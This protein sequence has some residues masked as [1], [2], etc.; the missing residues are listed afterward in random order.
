MKLSVVIP[1][2]NE[3][4]N[5]LKVIPELQAVLQSLEAVSEFE[6][7]VC[8]DHSSDNTFQ[9]TKDFNQKNIKA[10]RLSRRSGSHTAIRAGLQKATGDAVLCIS[11]DGQDNPSVLKEMMHKLKNGSHTVWAVRATRE[12]PFLQ[13]YAAQ[14]F[15]KLFTS[16]FNQPLPSVDLSNADFFLIDRKVV[17]GLNTCHERHTAL[18]GLLLHMG[19]NHD[20]VVYERRKRISGKSK[21]NFK[22][23]WK[24]MIDSFIAFSGFPIKLIFYIGILTTLI[25]LINAVFYLAYSYLEYPSPGWSVNLIATLLTS[26]V[27]M[28]MI[29]GI[30]EYLYRTLDESRKRPLFF[31]EDET[32]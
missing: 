25:G 23:K 27:Q 7:I 4:E 17:N 16:L 24:I 9:V 8:D 15:Y 28:I 18:L 21:W 13:K 29:G 12:E 20:Y 30:G 26:G 2:Y 14:L 19:F 22:S 1:A 6:I 11:A 3:A 31:L 10:L 5:I 32:A